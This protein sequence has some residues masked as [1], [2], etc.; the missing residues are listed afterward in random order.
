M[1]RLAKDL[2][3][4]KYKKMQMGR[5]IRSVQIPAEKYHL[6]ESRFVNTMSKMPEIPVELPA[7]TP[8]GNKNTSNEMA[9]ISAA[10]NITILSITLLL[11]CVFICFVTPVESRTRKYVVNI[12]YNCKC[13]RIDC[14]NKL[15]EAR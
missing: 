11:V 10:A 3:Y 6:E 12:L 13:I 15:L 2:L 1:V 7:I 4:L 9:E 8:L 5:L 14:C